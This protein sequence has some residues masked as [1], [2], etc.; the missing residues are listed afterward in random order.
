MKHLMISMLLG[1]TLAW[2]FSTANAGLLNPAAGQM[3]QGRHATER[4]N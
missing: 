3:E 2:W 4:N 1:A